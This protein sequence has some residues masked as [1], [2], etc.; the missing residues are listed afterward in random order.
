MGMKKPL[1]P[2]VSTSH[3][4]SGACAGGG[5]RRVSAGGP[6]SATA[7]TPSSASPSDLYP[8]VG[9]D[10]LLGYG[11]LTAAAALTSAAANG[12]GNK[13][14]TTVAA[15]EPPK[16]RPMSSME[17][18]EFAW[19][20]ASA[21]TP[22][23][24]TTTTTTAT[25]RATTA[26][27]DGRAVAS[28]TSRPRNDAI[29]PVSNLDHHNNS[30]KFSCPAGF[31]SHSSS[32]TVS[33][34]SDAA[35]AAVG[36]INSRSNGNECS[37]ST[38]R[39][40]TLAR[41]RQNSDQDGGGGGLSKPLPPVV[42][43]VGRVSLDQQSIH[44]LQMDPDLTTT[45][46]EDVDAIAEA[47][48][49]EMATTATLLTKG[50]TGGQSTTTTLTTT[51]PLTER[52]QHHLESSSLLSSTPVSMTLANTSSSLDN[53]GSAGVDHDPLPSS[54]QQHL[55]P[56][57]QQHHQVIRKKTSFAAKLRK[58]FNNSKSLPPTP[59]DHLTPTPSNHGA[60]V[61]NTAVTSTVS[62]NQ[63]Q[64]EDVVSLASGEDLYGSS[65]GGRA[66]THADMVAFMEQQQKHRGSV[67]SASSI[68]TDVQQP[69]H[70]HHRLHH[71]V[72][73]TF[74]R[75]SSQS[76]SQTDTPSTSPEATPCGSP[77]DQSNLNAVMA[78][79]PAALAP[80]SVSAIA[81]TSD[82]SLPSES[83]DI[84]D[85]LHHQH[86]L[87]PLSGSES[88]PS[89]SAL[90]VERASA[91]TTE[92]A[93]IV[94]PTNQTA[95]DVASA[96][97]QPPSKTN[98]TSTVKKRLS[99]ASISSFFS[100]RNGPNGS[101]ST[102]AQQEARA[103]QQR[104]SSVPHVENPLV[105]V[106]RQIAGFQRRHSLNDLHDSKAATS[107]ANANT[108]LK[109][110]RVGVN[111]LE[112]DRNALP[113]T[114]GQ[115]SSASAGAAAASTHF[116]AGH[117]P[118]PPKPTKKLSL[119]IVFNKGLR[120][121]KN[122]AANAS[123][124]ES[125]LPA[126]PL[127][128][129]LANRNNGSNMAG[130][131]PT[132]ASPPKV[133]LVHRSAS[134]RRSASIR[135]QG[136]A[137]RRH[138]RNSQHGSHHHHHHHHHNV[139]QHTDPFAR[140]AEAN[141]AL[142]NLN[143][144]G[145]QD[146]AA[147]RRPQQQQQR[148]HSLEEFDFCA[149]PVSFD[150]PAGGL[151]ILDTQGLHYQHN[152]QSQEGLPITPTRPTA[153]DP[154]GSSSSLTMDTG[155]SNAFAT[156]PTSRVLPATTKPSD[157]TSQSR[158]DTHPITL[159]RPQYTQQHNALSTLSPSSSC[160]SYSSSSSSDRVEGSSFRSTSD[161]VESCSSSS[162]SSKQGAVAPESG[163]AA[164]TSASGSGSAG[165]GSTAV[166]NPLLPAS[167]ARVS[168]NRIAM[169]SQ[170]GCEH[171]SSDISS[172]DGSTSGSSNG[173]QS[174]GEG[175]Q[176][177]KNNDSE[178]LYD[179]RL[180]TAATTASAA[181]TAS[182][183]SLTLSAESASSMSNASTE[184]SSTASSTTSTS[185]PTKKSVAVMNTVMED[186]SEEEAIMHSQLAYIQQQQQQYLAQQTQ[187]QLHQQQQQQEHH[188]HHHHVHYLPHHPHPHQHHHHYH[189]SS[190]SQ[191]QGDYE[192]IPSQ[193][194][195]HQPYYYPHPSLF[196]PR[197]PPSRLTPAMAN[198]IK[199]E[200]NQFKSQEMLVHEESRV[201]THF[202]I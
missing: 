34:V 96:L 106:G 40:N 101:N 134:R 38:S 88:S 172:N 135:S 159:N 43:A 129:A 61:T 26:E 161:D 188:H 65:N 82:S 9:R 78:G 119:N 39:S 93:H 180:S 35:A 3:V 157:S 179:H 120:K 47:E 37:N 151:P 156:L 76:Q 15:V 20:P 192:P 117:A 102:T 143:R 27:A 66:A 111:P 4:V 183:L 128:S 86:S 31:A 57:E 124:P 107:A 140:L 25:A 77:T 1:P 182:A 94:L 136:S 196:P 60:S 133:H 139:H 114:Q 158:L 155:S 115:G 49:E 186:V 67:S 81:L 176:G 175:S 125:P 16:L 166:F 97:Q 149:S 127:R 103:K 132:A 80:V 193:P 46:E 91:L 74:R 185:S 110:S 95:A 13:T 33:S 32:N 168:V 42:V 116:M 30:N 189:P 131:S 173:S 123:K 147:L 8:L 177:G 92:T 138:H 62:Q 163:V 122:L 29:A 75:G 55:Q 18:V 44:P 54:L 22:A 52:H 108:A 184:G 174:G 144:R 7:T 148:Q 130:Q 12:T 90:D 165:H 56:K 5:A 79:T 73:S 71:H 190:S 19:S 69:Q 145:S 59:Q 162:S 200:L 51:L 2:A 87:H 104:A 126:K 198:K 142:A 197:P 89:P 137:H 105:T 167:A 21:T 70:P 199:L 164:R 202:F 112:K 195:H 153:E 154:Q 146:Q 187:H 72:N 64:T 170:P 84:N 11:S 194:H 169:E 181:A 53:A 99:F 141:H 178:T 152:N 14:A 201:Y 28:K 100:P 109:I 6:G 10:V 23:S 160:C 58:V 171:S 85:G 118:V 41:H 150:A 17:N 68:D 24:P 98:P 121:K 48:A 113:S 45:T 63:E 36:Y 191:K 50:G 83:N